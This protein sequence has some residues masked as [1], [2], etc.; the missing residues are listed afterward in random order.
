ML[1]YV[2]LTH[3]DSCIPRHGPFFLSLHC[4]RVSVMRDPLYA[5]LEASSF[6]MAWCC[7]QLLAVCVHWPKQKKFYEWFI[8]SPLSES[9][10]RGLATYGY[11]VFGCIQVPTLT[12]NQLCMVTYFYGAVLAASVLTAGAG[13]GFRFLHLAGL[14]LSILYHGSLWA[15]RA[16]SHH[17][18][19]LA[20]TVWLY[21]CL[22][23]DLS[24]ACAAFRLHICSIYTMSVVQKTVTSM[25]RGRSWS[26]W[27]LH[28]FLWK[29]MWAKPWCPAL[30]RFI[31]LH[32]AVAHLC[33][34][35]SMVCELGPLLS[36]FCT[37]GQRL[38]YLALMGMHVAVVFVQGI[39]YVSYWTPSLLVG[40]FCSSD[41]IALTLSG[42]WSLSQLPMLALLGAQLLFAVTTAENFNINLPP[43]MSCPMFV[44][45]ARLDDK[46]HQHY[47]M[48]LDGEIPYERIEWMYPFVKP[49]YGMGILPSDVEHFP[50]PFV[51]FGWGGSLEGA[52][53][54]FHRWFLEVK[55]FYFMTNVPN[56][57]EDLRRELESMM[58]ELHGS[59]S[60]D[61]YSQLQS[62]ADRCSAA[63]NAFISH[64]SQQKHQIIASAE[65]MLGKGEKGITFAR[66][67]CAQRYPKN[68]G[69]NRWSRFH[70][71]QSFK[72]C[73]YRLPKNQKIVQARHGRKKYAGHGR[74]W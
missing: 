3:L 38:A 65:P 49:E 74:T 2:A 4:R 30:Q 42:N 40:L 44:T 10:R 28:G 15:E 68:S 57:P 22:A 71:F 33:G 60:N 46:C 1:H 24:T 62:L 13:A 59:N 6:F 32:P 63:R 19:I 52:P 17:R 47:V 48:M 58:V 55:G 61:P 41:P 34:W 21:A 67:R 31:F 27:S 35:M 37:T 72:H 7:C 11:A 36:L 64:A 5:S 26:K 53:R 25:I 29:S 9:K 20:I 43:L 16:S 45:I 39:D 73:H 51:A 12:S 18:E 23:P 8:R 50:M 70:F 14:L 69:K 66:H 54:I 56:F